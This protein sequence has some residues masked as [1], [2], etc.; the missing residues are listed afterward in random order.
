MSDANPFITHSDVNIF[1][2]PLAEVTDVVWGV[3][4]DDFHVEGD[5]GFRQLRNL[6]RFVACR[7]GQTAVY[8]SEYCLS[9]IHRQSGPSNLGATR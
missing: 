4:I 8:T 5:V 9:D 6:L 3:H 1:V 7:V 2:S